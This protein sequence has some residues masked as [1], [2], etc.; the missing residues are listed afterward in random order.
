M[1][2]FDRGESIPRTVTLTD[3]T[4]NLDTANFTDIIVK[5]THKHL[6]TELGRYSL[7]DSSVTKESPTSGG[8]ITFIVEDSTTPSAALGV[9]QYQVKTRETDADYE[10]SIR[11]RTFVGD[12]FYLKKAIT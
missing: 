9:Y 6:K 4:N 8:Q 10:S 5:V 3:G 7:N 11:T 2:N 1:D 12:C